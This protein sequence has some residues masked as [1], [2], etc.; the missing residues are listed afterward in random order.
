MAQ[1]QTVAVERLIVTVRG[2]RVILSTDLA[3]IYGVAARAL[4]QAVKR[5]AERFPPDFVIRLTRQDAE[6]IQR[7]RSQIVILKRGQNIKYPPLAFTER[8]S[9]G[10]LERSERQ[11]A[12]TP[13]PAAARRR[14]IAP[15]SAIPDPS[16]RFTEGSGMYW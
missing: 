15:N 16:I 13:R 3:A 6:A 14:S 9:D 10:P 11:A 1:R 8:L 2:Q 7:S 4:N 12:T 5:N